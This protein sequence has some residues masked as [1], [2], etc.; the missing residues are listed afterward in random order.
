MDLK[1]STVTLISVYTVVWLFI[2][3]SL[4]LSLTETFSF[5]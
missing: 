5:C 4:F 1:L 2:A 3:G